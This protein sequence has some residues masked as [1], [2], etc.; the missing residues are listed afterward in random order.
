[1]TDENQIFVADLVVSNSP[2]KIVVRS[3]ISKPTSENAK[4]KAIAKIGKYRKLCEGHH[5]I[6]MALEV[7]NA[8]GHDMDCF[9]KECACL[10]HDK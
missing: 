7:H 2:W 1:M 6:T 3:V 10:F 8:T 4:P 9:I 5:F